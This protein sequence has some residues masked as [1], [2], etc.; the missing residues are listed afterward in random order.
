MEAGALFITA[1]VVGLSGAMM[2]G[3]FL[4][5]AIAESIRRGFWA[6]PWMVLGHAILELILVL[7]LLEGLASFLVRPDVTSVIAGLGGAFLLLM[8]LAMS[9]DALGGRISLDDALQV[10]G[11]KKIRLHPVAAGIAFSLA[12]PLWYLWWSTV[13]LSY[14]SLAMKSGTVGLASFYSG[15]IIADLAWYSLV[16]MAVSGGRKVL[17]QNVYNFILAACGIFLLGLGVYFIYSGFQY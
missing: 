8:G 13:G 4:T 3:P 7:A 15:H 9:R 17:S 6:G 10:S 1:F 14:I 12:N 5:A 2:P 16:S 11:Q